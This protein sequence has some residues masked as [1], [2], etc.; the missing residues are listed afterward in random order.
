MEAFVD[1][2]ED[3]AEIQSVVDQISDADKK[4]KILDFIVNVPDSA[5]ATHAELLEKFENIR[6]KYEGKSRDENSSTHQ[7]GINQP[8]G[9]KLKDLDIPEFHG[10][11]R[12]F[13]H[14]K[15]I[16]ESL[17]HDNPCYTNPQRMS[18]LIQSLKDEAGKVLSDTTKLNL[19]Y[20]EAWSLVCEWYEKS[21]F[22]RFFKNLRLL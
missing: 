9:P 7:A 11:P 19:S 15:G 17:V 14:F 22:Y 1:I 18:Y 13:I 3:S 12:E 16:F 20:P 2:R 8:I 10:N 6:L 4:Q 5:R 21:I